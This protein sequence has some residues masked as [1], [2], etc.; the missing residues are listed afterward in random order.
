MSPNLLTSVIAAQRGLETLRELKGGDRVS[1]ALAPGR[2]DKRTTHK[3]SSAESILAH[4]LKQRGLTTAWRDGSITARQR[5]RLLEDIRLYGRRWLRHEAESFFGRYGGRGRDLVRSEIYPL[6]SMDEIFHGSADALAV[7]RSVSDSILSP[8]RRWFTRA[9]NFVRELIFAGTMTL[10]GQTLTP[11]ESGQADKLASIQD[12]YFDKFERE[13]IANPP[14]EIAESSTSPTVILSGKQPMS[15]A[16]FAA[17]AESYADS[18]WQGAQRIERSAVQSG[19]IQRWE[20]RVVGH[21]KTEHCTDCPPLAAMGWQ[22]I[23]TLPPI[24]DSECGHLCLCH[25]VYSDA[26]EK[27]DAKA[28]K[29]IRPGKRPQRKPAGPKPIPV[30][31]EDHVKQVAAEPMAIP[32]TQEEHVK[33]VAQGRSR[34]RFR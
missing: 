18:A 16:Q 9:R 13:L 22:P 15:P 4:C 3:A 31:H 12:E 27:P 20:R 19:D 28:T 2:L 25:F 26:A 32:V 1:R 34:W 23:G 10:R 21:P 5:I 7:T 33:Q 8:L 6:N 14:R 17:R 11:Q 30:T 24:G 29:P